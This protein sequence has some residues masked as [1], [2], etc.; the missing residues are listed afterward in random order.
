MKFLKWK[1]QVENEKVKVL[2]TEMVVEGGGRV[3]VN[4]SRTIP[5][6]SLVLW[7]E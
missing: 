6:N 4:G 3:F 5:K 2:G 7:R 1:A